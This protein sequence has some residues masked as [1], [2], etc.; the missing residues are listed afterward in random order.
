MGLV[1]VDGHGGLA[2]PAIGLG[3]AGGGDVA[4][5]EAVARQMIARIVQEV[6]VATLPGRLRHDLGV[7]RP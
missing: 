2:G 7:L 5:D 3:G 6:D 1:A 4:A